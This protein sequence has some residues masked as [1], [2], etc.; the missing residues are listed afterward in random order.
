MSIS[1]VSK[2]SRAPPVAPFSGPK[3][4]VNAALP[5]APVVGVVIDRAQTLLRQ[6]PRAPNH[7][8]RVGRIAILVYV[9]LGFAFCGYRARNHPFPIPNFR[10]LDPLVG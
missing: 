2:V 8:P 3:A 9:E 6:P 10:A 4:K 5:Q 7:G 1:A